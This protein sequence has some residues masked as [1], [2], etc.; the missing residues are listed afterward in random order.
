VDSLHI[1]PELVDVVSDGVYRTTHGVLVLDEYAGPIYI[2]EDYETSTDTRYK[3][4]WTHPS[5]RKQGFLDM[6]DDMSDVVDAWAIYR[7]E[8]QCNVCNL[9]YHSRLGYCPNC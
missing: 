6:T 2:S 9:M 3:E 7:K 4:W 5:D 1:E 8:V